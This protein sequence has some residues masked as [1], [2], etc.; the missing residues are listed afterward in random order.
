[1]VPTRRR[2]RRSP[3]RS[4]AQRSYETLSIE[5]GLLAPEWLDKVAGLDAPGQSEADYRVPRGLSL[6][7][8]I[9]RYWRVAQAHFSD[10]TAGRVARAEPRALAERFVVSLLREAFCFQSLVAVAP[11]VFSER[12][13]P[14]GH[15]ALSGR[16][17]IV[18]APAGLGLEAA[19]P[20]FPDGARRRS[21]FGLVQE[22]L[23][24]AEG[25]LWGVACDGQTL[26]ILRDNASL[27]RPAWIEADLHRIFS[28][29]RYADFAALWLLLHE[30]RFGTTDQPVTGCV[31]ESWR[32]AGR[33]EGTRA[34][35]HL[36]RGVE[37][38]LLALGHGFLSHKDNGA[39]RAALE[40]GS[41]KEKDYF[42][43]LLRLVYR[44]IFLLTVEERGLLHPDKTP[45]AV[46]A[47]YA[48]GYGLRRLRER[49][50]KRSAYD[51]HEDL[52]AA[53]LIVLRGVASGEPRLG[54]PA[55]AGIFGS[56][57]CPALDT[58]K[59]EN[60][61]LLVA[62]FKLSWLPDQG[63]L[64]RV[65]W[66]DMGPEEL[67]SVYE[68]LLELVP[69]LSIPTRS[70]A[71]AT[72]DETKGNARKTTGS[73]Y[74]PDSLVQV[75]LDS[76]LEPVIKARLTA[77]PDRP[78]EALLSLSIVDPACGSGH[79]LLAAARRLAGH[80]ARLKSSGTPSAAEY[81]SA[82]R[83]VV[84][85]CIYGV[86]LNPMAI[87]LCKVALWME[88][89]EPGLPLSFLDAH[90]QCGN[91]LLGT[92]PELMKGGIPDAAW[93]PIEGD[94]R[95][96][97]SSLKK[98]NGK[99]ALGQKTLSLWSEP[100][101]EPQAVARAV[102]ELE[103]APD[104]DAAELAAKESRWAAI[105]A[106]GPFRHQRFVAD[107]WCAA[108]VWPKPDSKDAVV[109][110]APTMGLWQDIR[111][112]KGHPPALTV[113]TV[114]ALAAQYHFF[115]WHVA[116]PTVFERGGFDVVLGNPPWE[117]V[118]IQEQE[119]FA[120]R[121]G[122]IA[123]AVNAAARKKLIAALPKTDPL[124]WDAWCAASREAEG[125]S[126]LIRDSGRYPL[127]GKGDVNTY[128]IFAEHNLN[129]IGP[130]GRAGFIVPSGIAT[131]DTTKEYFGSLAQAGRLSSLFDFRNHDGLFYDVGHRRF[132][133]CLLTV[134]GS[135]AQGRS[136]RFVF[137][138]ESAAELRDP[139]RQFSL[140]P[141][142]IS[143]LNPNTGT[144][145]TFR[146]R[147]DAV[148]NLAMY[149]H[150]GILWRESDAADSNPWQL[151]FMRMFDMANDS[152]LFRMRAALDPKDE[153][154]P[155]F[156]AKMVHHF[157]HRYGD[158]ADKRAGSLDTQLP[159]VPLQRLADPMYSPTP[160]YWVPATEVGTRLAGKWNRGWLL[161]WRDICRSTDERT[162]IASVIPRT[163]VGDKF[164]IMLSA[165]EPQM[166]ACL[167][168]S[169]CSFALDYAARQK[170]GGT[171]L[172]YFTMKQFPVLA[173]NTYYAD[174][175]WKH[176]TVL[177]DFILPRVLE[178]TY[179]AWD[180]EPFACDVEYGG[181]PFRW[182]PDRRF[183]LRCEL[184]AAFFH[185]YGLSRDDTDYV[186]ETFPIVRK[187]D[188]KEHGEYRTKR[189]ILEIYDEMA[190]ASRTGRPYQTRL[191]PPP[192]DPRVA[193]PPRQAAR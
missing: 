70:F 10:F 27:T 30:T 169:L 140:S 184:D 6:R 119:F 15:A 67:G 182:D 11:V 142:D 162:I 97:A 147:R 165:A 156:E 20:L 23:N 173:P 112:G 187:S 172:K 171:S 189:V 126:H 154:L 118:K 80:V 18:V 138:A 109:E 168:G 17:P 86:D 120:S 121:S 170:V 43:Q 74:T 181:P 65:N 167:Y 53:T 78:I 90:L 7:D 41:L 94:D 81:R 128:S 160:Q 129:T 37:D 145:S 57:Q 88:A 180:L 153:Y 131:D 24:A 44:L 26:R 193:H 68:S 35:E 179:T 101:P 130:M 163:A 25:A 2:A 137:F 136:A 93:E 185:L 124:L 5:G 29:E 82:L 108:F 54:L 34:R 52:W 76:A 56:G 12:T 42:N 144:C 40:D 150:A 85:R 13:Y 84:G 71:F 72:G 19:S 33:A 36:R 191:D 132:K 111:D 69:V 8:E 178:L 4:E 148:M 38:S 192:A 149:R 151:R 39:L 9:G 155:L 61:S 174:T 49:A 127:C 58:A 141:A 92:T 175:L 177:R 117:R 161:G 152:D 48:E 186:M 21:A 87:E 1:M 63:G 116:F 158:Y 46:R 66:R 47:L 133:F 45:D 125:Q 183:L 77:Q 95:K 73:Y 114:E 104:G 176:G 28:E 55:L 146:S 139:E 59:L 105:L 106:S 123:K 96:I 159:D 50:A 122:E 3:R 98:R 115:H 75:L 83:Q 110:V 166:I 16:V 22:Y 103:A 62:V 91:A 60:R 99:E 135:C 113:T 79:F 107:A 188:K 190:E 102:A 164:L 100:T 31:L 14:I 134:L 51:R 64:S 32:D 143:L 89:V 157:D